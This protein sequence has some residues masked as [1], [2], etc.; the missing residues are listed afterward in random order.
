MLYLIIKAVVS[1]GIIALVSEVARRS[2]FWGALI[3]SLP[4]VS[5][6]SRLWLWR[7][8]GDSALAFS[9]HGLLATRA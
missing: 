4:L 8:T 3:L 7:D 2:S 1:G 5:I 6:L 9:N